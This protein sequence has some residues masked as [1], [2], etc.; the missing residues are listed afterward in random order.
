[1]LSGGAFLLLAVVYSF[2]VQRRE[3][4]I[5]PQTVLCVIA[6]H[7]EPLLCTSVILDLML[8]NIWTH[9]SNHSQ[10]WFGSN[11]LILLCCSVFLKSIWIQSRYAKNGLGL[12]V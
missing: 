7:T 1:M 9:I 12:A 3:L 5:C 6:L 10:M 2:S 8:W 4:S 11:L